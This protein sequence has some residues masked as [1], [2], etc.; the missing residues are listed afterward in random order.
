M[1][2]LIAAIDLKRGIA[3]DK[4]IPWKLPSD[5]RYFREK[6]KGFV[7]LMGANVYKEKTKPFPDRTNV[8]L[9]YSTEPLREGFIAVNNLQVFFEKYGNQDLWIIGGASLFSQTIDLADELY[10][11]QVRADFNC[12]KFFPAY[13]DKFVLDSR[14]EPQTEGGISF[15][16]D[17]WV[18]RKNAQLN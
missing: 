15:C 5:V 14:S 6:T 2:R 9:T 7:I 11:T 12:T 17:V 4:G 13:E 18:K 10:L 1:I 3:T 16:F 8:V